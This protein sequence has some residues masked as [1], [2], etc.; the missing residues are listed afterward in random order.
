MRPDGSHR[1]RL[2]RSTGNSDPS[3]SVGG[4]IA[5]THYPDDFSGPSSIVTRRA[6]GRLVSRFTAAHGVGNPDFS[7]HGKLLTFERYDNTD[8]VSIWRSRPDG[9]RMRQ[10]VPDGH[11][12]AWSPSGRSIAYSAAPAPFPASYEIFIVRRDGSHKHQLGPT[13]RRHGDPPGEYIGPA[14]QPLP[15]R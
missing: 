9:S 5:Y 3:W 7:P 1:R 2:T 8:G 15:R 6:D 12:P 13:P 4:L 14:W 11:E 10:V